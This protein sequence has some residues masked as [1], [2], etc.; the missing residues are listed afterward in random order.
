ML[1]P[2]SGSGEDAGTRWNWDSQGHRASRGRGKGGRQGAHDEER[3]LVR[4][5]ISANGSARHASA[6]FAMPADQLS[7]DFSRPASVALPGSR[8]RM[9]SAGG[10][11]RRGA[12][13]GP[14]VRAARGCSTSS[15][16]N[17]TAFRTSLAVSA[18]TPATSSHGAVTR[19]ARSEAETAHAR[20]RESGC[21]IAGDDGRTRMGA[22]DMRLCAS[23]LAATAAHAAPL[24]AASGKAQPADV[25]ASFAVNAPHSTGPTRMSDCFSSLHPELHPAVAADASHFAGA[26]GTTTNPSSSLTRT[27]YAVSREGA[28]GQAGQGRREDG[29]RTHFEC[30]T[31]SPGPRTP[32][33]AAPGASSLLTG[34]LPPISAQTFRSTTHLRPSQL[35][36]AGTCRGVPA[37]NATNN[38][39][40]ARE[41]GLKEEN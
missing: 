6:R 16:S 18:S 35:A 37:A 24:S 22:E 25:T 29:E 40:P 2:P 11:Q 36:S 31:E 21:E 4:T 33:C 30:V 26:S 15:A 19:R 8:I 27:V 34:H 5:P 39:R 38:T 3:Q 20:T 13:P 7:D 1:R 28:P 10:S 9:S 32:R 41:A 12:S 17:A 14:V 23:A